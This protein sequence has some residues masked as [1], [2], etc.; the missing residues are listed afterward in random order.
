MI[1]DIQNILIESDCLSPS[2]QMQI[3]N[4]YSK[5]VNAEELSKLSESVKHRSTH[6][7]FISKDTVKIINFATDVNEPGLHTTDQGVSGFSSKE[8][9]PQKEEVLSSKRGKSLLSLPMTESKSQVKQFKNLELG[10]ELR[11]SRNQ[12]QVTE[13]NTVQDLT[14]KQKLDYICMANEL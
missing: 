1:K 3:D 10:E 6:H 13:F 12:Q 5:L 7:R 4:I 2:Y 11:C 14:N 9:S 8:Q